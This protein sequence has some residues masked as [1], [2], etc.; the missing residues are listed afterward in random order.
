MTVDTRVFTADELLHLPEDG[1][2]HELVEGELRK[3]SPAGG[4]HGRIGARIAAR[5]LTYAEQ[6][7]LGVVYSSDTGFLLSR[8]PDTVRAPDVAFNRTERAVETDGYLPSAPDLAIEVVSPSDPYTEVVQK[9]T[10]YLRAGSLA[11][12][13]VDPW[14]RVVRIH[15]ARA[16]ETITTTVTEVLEIDDVVPGWRLPLDD[17]F[18]A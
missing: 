3:M 14:K 10:E 15:R 1:C 16:T 18:S 13:V 11:V 9:T 5:L 17:I 8:S 2:R 4:K 7:K 12:V 6:H